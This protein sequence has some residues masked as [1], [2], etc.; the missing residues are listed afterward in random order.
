MKRLI[1]MTAIVLAGLGWCLPGLS[2][3]TA[4]KD[5]QDNVYFDKLSPETFLT[6]SYTANT[7]SASNRYHKVWMY[8]KPNSTCQVHEL[9]NTRK[10]FTFSNQV[11][12]KAVTP[13]DVTFL[14]TGT[15]SQRIPTVATDTNPCNGTNRNTSVNWREISPGIFAHRTYQTCFRQVVSNSTG[16]LICLGE[17]IIHIFGL[18]GV[19]YQAISPVAKSRFAKSNGCGF[20]KLPNSATWKA[21]S[22]DVIRLRTDYDFND[23]RYVDYGN[24]TRATL[25]VRTA[26]QIPRCFDG[27]RFVYQP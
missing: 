22:N 12:L 2:Q 1:A 15:V 27:K 6:I 7:A 4:Y 10:N 16:N 20:V 17:D 11:T 9:F 13:A 3:V 23:D 19:S 5:A 8:K 18:P 24:F 21:Y 26:L 14:L 25:P